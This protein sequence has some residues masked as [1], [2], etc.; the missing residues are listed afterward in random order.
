MLDSS[1][2]SRARAWVEVRLD[3]LRENAAA[4]QRAIGVNA[5]LVPMV[6]A[7]A[8]GLGMAPVV[9]ALRDFPRPADPWAFGV[10]AI[11]EGESLRAAGWAGRILVFSPAPLSE[12]RRAAEAEL[13]LCISELPAVRELADVARALDRTIPFHVEIDTGMGRAG[14]PW[15]EAAS[16][17]EALLAESSG[18]RWEGTYTHFHSADEADRGPTQEQWNRFER[19]LAELPDV[20][21]AP[22]LHVAN[23][24]GILRFG[25]F[26]CDLARPGIFLYGGKAG[27]ETSPAPVVSVRARV[28]LVRDVE[29]GATVG[30]GA[31]HTASGVERWATL[32][33]GYGDGIPRAL[34]AGGGEVLV[35]G[36][37]VPIV[38]RISMDMTTIDVTGLP[39]VRSGDIATLIGADGDDGITVDEVAARCGTISYEILT[40]LGSRLPRVYQQRE[41]EGSLAGY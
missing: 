30:Y 23:S 8:Y 7:E 28:V 9:A 3:R 29:P 32:S 17:G 5:G 39:G 36:R 16:W 18:L 24:A 11:A 38:G 35:R 27:P 10:A 19:A 37:R 13:T 40:G 33:I 15:T 34:A 26:G 22:I 41:L 1:T 21:P 20:E 14:F 12:F 31:T 4:A 25:G 6:K 2:A